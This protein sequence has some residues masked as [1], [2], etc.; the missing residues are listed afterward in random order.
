MLGARAQQEGCGYDQRPTFMRCSH[1]A[2]E[3]C[4]VLWVQVFDQYL[5]SIQ[6]YLIGVFHRHLSGTRPVFDHCPAPRL[7][8]SFSFLP[9]FF[10]GK[11][12]GVR[13][14]IAFIPVFGQCSTI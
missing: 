6:W 1:F 4:L 5:T 7:T 14:G 12:G 10:L 3:D 2:C 11:R 8:R 13:A 9:S